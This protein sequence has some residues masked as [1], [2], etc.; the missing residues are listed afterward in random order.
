MVAGFGGGCCGTWRRQRYGIEQIDQLQEKEEYWL[1]EGFVE[2]L[3]SIEIADL[4]EGE[5]AEVRS[6]RAFE[7]RFL[8]FEASFFFGVENPFSTPQPPPS[9]PQL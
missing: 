2:E 7:L 8:F 5:E 4:V 6:S 9:P 3:V 1:D